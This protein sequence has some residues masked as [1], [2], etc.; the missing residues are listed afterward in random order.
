[1]NR[2]QGQGKGI[3]RHTAETNAVDRRQAQQRIWVQN[4]ML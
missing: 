1:M 2:I 3:K 4:G